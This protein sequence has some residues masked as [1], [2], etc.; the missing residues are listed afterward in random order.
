MLRPGLLRVSDAPVLKRLSTLDRYLPLWIFGAMGSGLLLGR[1]FPGL[2]ASLD[3]VQVAG[4]SVP[5]GLGL[6][7]MMYPVLAKVRYESI[8]S[9][10]ADR[11][12]IGTSLLLNWVIGPVV[13]FAL[14]WW[15]LPD[16]PAYRNGLVIVGLARCIAMVLIWNTLAG[17]SSELAAVLVALN[18]IFQVLTYSLLGYLFLHVV[19]GWLGGT[20]AALDVSMLD[21]ARSRADLPRRAA[22]GR[23]LDA[24]HPRPPARG[25]VVRG[26]ASSRASAPRRCSGCSTRSS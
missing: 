17:G 7:W 25:G 8:G 6:L 23:V 21:I 12:L 18:S 16:L 2:G 24:A 10:V 3:R 15:L 13:M 9:H 5:I 14:A 11:R 1:L 4:V 26:L 20:T 22:A 19:P